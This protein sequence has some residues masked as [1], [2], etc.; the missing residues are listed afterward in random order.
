MDFQGGEIAREIKGNPPSLWG[1]VIRRIPKN[2][3]FILKEL[4]DKVEKAGEQALRQDFYRI[5]GSGSAVRRW[6][7]GCM[8]FHKL[9]EEKEIKHGN[10]KQKIYAITE[11]GKVWHNLLKNASGEDVRLLRRLSGR[12]LK[13]KY[14]I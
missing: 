6:V 5:L 9:L 3:P 11:R 7:D 2:P 13:S 1:K 4:L 10:K 8:I 12:R 14:A